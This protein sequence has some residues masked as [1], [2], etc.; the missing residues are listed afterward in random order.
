[1]MMILPAFLASVTVDLIPGTDQ[2]SW[3]LWSVEIDQRPEKF[4]QGFTGAL[5][6]QGKWEQA[7]GSLAQG[8]QAGSLYGVM[9]GVCPGVR[10]EELYR[11]FARPFSGVECRGHAYMLHLHPALQKL[12]LGSLFISLSIICSNCT[13]IQVIFSFCRDF[14]VRETFVRYKPWNKLSQPVCQIQALEQRIPACLGSI[15]SFLGN[16]TQLHLFFSLFGP[17]TQHVG[18]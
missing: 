17:A 14:L 4:R 9:A 6:Q 18:T 10:Q 11:W 16:E 5:L 1:M 15:V 12:G 2:G 8:R 13:C 3:P 7:T